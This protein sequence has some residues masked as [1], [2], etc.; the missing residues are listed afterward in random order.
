MAARECQ[1]LHLIILCSV[2]SSVMTQKI[3]QIFRQRAG[4]WKWGES[5]RKDLASLSFAIDNK[6]RL[7]GG[8]EHGDT[9]QIE[10]V[11]ENTNGSDTSFYVSKM[12]D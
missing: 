5:H 6:E 9:I 12:P 10:Q 8:G 7:L 3:Q 4:N 11:E 1:F 2:K